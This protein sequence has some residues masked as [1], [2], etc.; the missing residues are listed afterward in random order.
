VCLTQK[1]SVGLAHLLLLK[2][3]LDLKENVVGLVHLLLIKDAID[4][5]ETKS[6]GLLVSR[7]TAFYMPERCNRPKK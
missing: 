5:Q 2:G 6:V 3:V 4:L 7:S 1:K